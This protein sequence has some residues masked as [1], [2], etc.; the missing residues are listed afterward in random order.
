M[1]HEELK[2][3][4][5]QLI[6]ERVINGKEIDAMFN[7]SERKRKAIIEELVVSDGWRIITSKQAPYGYS[8]ARTDAEVIETCERYEREAIKLFRRAKI[9]RQKIGQKETLF[10]QDYV[11]KN[12]IEFKLRD[13]LEEVE[14]ENSYGS[15][16]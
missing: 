14:N 12:E 5:V 16:R 1:E 15:V 10:G 9:L 4:I 8:L 7:I 11:I 2:R 3:A 13:E 6:A